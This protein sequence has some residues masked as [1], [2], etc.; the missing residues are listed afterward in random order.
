VL[1]AAGSAAHSFG[2]LAIDSDRG[3]AYGFSYDQDSVE[4]ARAAAVENCGAD[5]SVVVT[6]EFA[7]AAYAA[8]Q[9]GDSGAYGWGYAPTRGRAQFL[10]MKF[11]DE[12]G[13]TDCLIRVW[14]CES[15]RDGRGMARFE[16]KPRPPQQ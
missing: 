13:G 16:G 2:A 5:C 14:A 15:L 1:C 3:P 12:F 4:A 11:C 10:A 8:D 7:C 9:S 6:F